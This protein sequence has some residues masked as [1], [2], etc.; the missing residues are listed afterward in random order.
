[1]SKYIDI[2]RRLQEG[3]AIWP[4][5]SAYEM[6]KTLAISNGHSVNLTSISLSAHT[7]SHIDAP[8]HFDDG[9]EKIEQLP[10][11]PYWG[12]AQVV[13]VSKAA[14]ALYPDDFH[15]CRLDLAPRLLVRSTASSLDQSI[16]PDE[17]VYPSP[18]LADFLG[19]LGL[20]LYGTDCP[21]M[22][23]PK[24]KSLEGHRALQRNGIAILEWLDLS[25]AADGLYDLSALPLRIVGGDGS[26]V[27]AVLKTIS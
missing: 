8:Y 3:T 26:P 27:R 10:I 15:G 2:T 22:D 25:K 1:M 13:R 19:A 7:G 18:E 24:S 21:S 9:G 14:G 6:S 11:E 16:F 12:A 23:H 20:I 17:F 5:D 4:G